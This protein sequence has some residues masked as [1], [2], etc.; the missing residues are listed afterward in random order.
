M[1]GEPAPRADGGAPVGAAGRLLD[2]ALA[3]LAI[4]AGLLLLG[5]TVLVTV[6]VLGRLP[7][8]LGDTWLFTTAI[9]ALFGP[10]RAHDLG[11]TLP[12]TTEVTEYALYW[13]T[14]LG[15]PWVLRQG[16]HISIDIVIQSI[17]AAGRAV[18]TRVVAVLG[19]AITGVL[20]YYGT[21]V[22]RK[23]AAE[24]T[25]IVKTLTV[26][27]WIVFAPLPVTSLLLL[28]VFL[29]WIARPPAPR[30]GPQEGL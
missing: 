12:W 29:G 21:A 27:E 2:G 26:A 15:A 14:F 22:V 9:P 19:A 24:G 20:L 7:G 11:F 10:V 16:G 28:L 25:T 3:A 4:A 17:G 18:V 5:V 30:H 23:A 1:T 8:R 6:D 13:M